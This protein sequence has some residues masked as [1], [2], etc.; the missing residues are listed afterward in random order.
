MKNNVKVISELARK[1]EMLY[2]VECLH[3]A[4]P[5]QRVIISRIDET[6][7]HER[8]Q[9]VIQAKDAE[10]VFK[11]KDAGVAKTI[12]KVISADTGATVEIEV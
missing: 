6:E 3:E 2:L 4:S 1:N 9:A 7:L 11:F 8:F 12:A 5:I 10:V